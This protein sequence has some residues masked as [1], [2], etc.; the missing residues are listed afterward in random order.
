MR[1]YPVKISGCEP[2]EN[3]E[4]VNFSIFISFTIWFHLRYYI[5]Y[6]Y[7]LEKKQD[8]FLYFINSLALE[9]NKK[10]NVKYGELA[11]NRINGGFPRY[12]LNQL[13]SSL[14]EMELLIE[15]ESVLEIE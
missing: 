10:R 1:I 12:V 4:V 13:N 9:I 5:Y 7:L 11:L 15:N 8:N 14:L 2:N 3:K 6:R